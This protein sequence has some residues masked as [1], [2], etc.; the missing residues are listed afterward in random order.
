MK[1]IGVAG[2]T[3]SGKNF[4][5]ELLED[6][7]WRTLDLDQVAHRSLDA[8]SRTIENQFGSEVMGSEGINR[9][10]LGQRVFSEPALLSALENITYPWIEEETRRWLAESPD[11]PAVIHAINLH[12]TSLADECDCIIWVRAPFYLRRKRV[13]NRENRPWKELRGRFR[14]Q[15]GLNPK[16]FSQHAEIYSVRNSGN[17]ASL[18]NALDR[19]LSRL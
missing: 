8:L 19:I 7:G 9:K 14:S 11:I 1:L 2:K 15:N 16:L 3:G 5:A 10:A 12:K 17:V 6:R 4:V 18:N 13:M